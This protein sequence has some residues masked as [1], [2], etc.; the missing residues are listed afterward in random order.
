MPTPSRDQ[1]ERAVPADVRPPK[2]LAKCVENVGWLH[3]AGWVSGLSFFIGRARSCWSRLRVDF[4]LKSEH[5]VFYLLTFSCYGHRLHGDTAGSVARDQNTPGTPLV[6]R[7]AGL[8][9]W[10]TSA[11]A[12]TPYLLDGRR[13]DCV[14]GAMRQRCLDRQWTLKAAHVRETHVHVVVFCDGPPE[15]V[16]T[17]LKSAASA[18]LNATG[19]DSGPRHRWARHGSTR[20]LWNERSVTAAIRYVVEQQGE[21]MAVYKEP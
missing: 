9:S 12:H 17:Q 8:K 16:L 13:R 10:V 5:R 21:P 1:Q 18:A 15:S 11:M 3:G 14:L 7:N 4:L 2:D 19:F 6:Q 20:W